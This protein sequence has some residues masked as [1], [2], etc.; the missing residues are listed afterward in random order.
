LIITSLIISLHTLIAQEGSTHDFSI[1]NSD[2]VFSVLH[3][4]SI[5]VRDTITHDSV[6][7]FLTDKLKLPVYYSPIIYGK[8]KYAGV[9]AGN[10]VLEP[11]GPYSNFKYA[12]NDFRAIFFGLTFE[13]YKSISQTANGL[14]TKKISSEVGEDYIYL[15][16]SLLCGENI[17]ISFM[18]KGDERANDKL[19]M[20][21]LRYALTTRPEN[22]LGIEYISEIQI[23]YKDN[24]NLMKWKEFMSPLKL[25]DSETLEGNNLPEI[26][27]CK[28]NIKE[29]Q[30][31]TFK[32][33]S[34]EKAKKYL[35]NNNLLGRTTSDKIQLNTARTFGLTIYISE[36]ER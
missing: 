18:D 14:A 7:L 20:E 25:A 4:L 8:R 35:A 26:H 2:P 16:D 28:S 5:H 30:S 22:E 6:F 34:L 11:C 21:I 19:K 1:P 15:K 32:V 13:P 3:T 27:F 9:Y 12:S 29:V 31:I 36:N 10:L 24:Y 17:T 23:G 33:R